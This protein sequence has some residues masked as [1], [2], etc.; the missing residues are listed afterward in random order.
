MRGFFAGLLLLFASVTAA[1]AEER[2]EHFVSDATIN[3]DGTV[4]V[5]ETIT[6][7]AE[8]IDIRRGIYRDF[9]TTYEDRHG[10]RIKT[11]FDVL[12]VRRNG[13]DEPYRTESQSNGVRLYIGDAD[14]LIGRGRHAYEIRYRTHRQLGFFNDYDEFYWNVT[15]NGWVF[16]IL[17]ATSTVRLPPGARIV[18][19]AAY[20]GAS[21]A[22]GQDFRIISATGHVFEAETTLPLASF[23]GFTVAVAWQK[24]VVTPPSVSDQWQWWASDNAGV[25]AMLATLLAGAAYYLFAWDRVGRDPPSGT[26]VPLFTPPPGMGPAGA[27]FVRKHGSD[28]K[29][30][31]AALVSLAVKK[32]LKIDD[33]DGSFTITRLAAPSDAPALTKAEHAL[34]TALPS[35]PLSLKQT[36]HAK[37][38]AARTALSEALKTEYEGSIFIR[39]IGWF[40]AGAA[41]SVLGLVIAALLMPAHE[42]LMG[43]FAAGWSGIWWA[44]ILTVGYK[45]VKGAAGGGIM[46]K[47]GSIGT[48]LF[49]IPFVGGG[50]AA[51]AAM[52]FG[53]GSTALYALVGTAI[54][55]G[56][57]NLVFYR[58]LRAPTPPGRKVLD[59]LEGFRMYMATAEEERLKVLH[60]PDK[61]PELFERY[62]P[63]ALAL[64]CENQWNSKF[65]TVLAAAAA[66]G[67]AAPV[68]YSGSNWNDGRSGDFTDSLGRGLSSTISSAST[69]PGSSSG[70]SGGGSSGGGGGGG[71]GGGW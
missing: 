41:I 51:P 8:G 49:L 14:V 9:P 43:L 21:G 69:A 20:T 6:V 13:R 32:R 62:L 57:M 29:G 11:S 39:N 17:R 25:F 36:N 27:R 63:Y 58:L 19:H 2:I 38:R 45:A 48:L 10:F 16:P 31:A 67:A 60:P 26:I 24:G 56:I 37:V 1:L 71:G 40:W 52:L 65:A 59:H 50:I 61:T 46:S 15:G 70:S 35:G 53:G 22:T 68:W 55:L 12:A 54:L 33:D 7:N 4:E 66:A 3:R 28:D 5:I 42:G 23:E 34:Y 30:F 64:D 47:I 18:Q 44:V